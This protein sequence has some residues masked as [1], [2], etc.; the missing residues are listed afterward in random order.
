MHFQAQAQSLPSSLRSKRAC[1]RSRLGMVKTTCRCATGEQ[2]SSATCRAVSNV[3][4][5]WQ[6]GQVQRCLQEKATNISWRQSGQRTRAKPSCRSP[7]LRK[8]ATERCDDR[9]PVAVLGLEAIV[10]DLLEGLEMLVQQAPQVGGLRIAWAVE[11]Q[12]LD[13]RGRH[14]GKGT[15]PAR[16][17]ARITEHAYTYRQANGAAGRA[18]NWCGGRRLRRTA[19]FPPRILPVEKVFTTRRRRGSRSTHG[20]AKG[21]CGNE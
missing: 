18:C 15:C 1:S 19:P 8:A 9:P 16:V 7:H 3:R 14:D 11:G 6:E 20:E 17:Y 21:Q 10:V 13:T 12:R 4:F 2:T 5:W